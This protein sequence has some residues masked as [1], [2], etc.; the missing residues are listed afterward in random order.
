[1]IYRHSSIYTVNVGTQKKC[2]SKNRVNRG[3]LDFLNFRYKY[4]LFPFRPIQMQQSS[5][6]ITNG[7]CY[8][9]A[10]DGLSDAFLRDGVKC[11]R[12][13]CFFLLNHS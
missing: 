9:V 5:I 8:A 7:D 2:G 11:R 1:M 12:F 10:P 13:V 4:H 6:N 3:Y